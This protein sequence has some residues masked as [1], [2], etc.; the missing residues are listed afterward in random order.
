MQT[1]FIN[2]LGQLAIQIKQNKEAGEAL[3]KKYNSVAAQAAAV[4]ELEN[5]GFEIVPQKVDKPETKQ[6]E[7]T[8]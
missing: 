7:A 2:Q 6:P 8:A 3:D 5:K 4:Q 1:E